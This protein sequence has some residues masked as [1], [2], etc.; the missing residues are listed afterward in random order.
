MADYE[1]YKFR[2]HGQERTGYF[3]SPFGERIAR[4]THLKSG[5]KVPVTGHKIPGLEQRYPT[6]EDALRDIA[7]K[8]REM[9]GEGLDDPI[10]QPTEARTVI[11]GTVNNL[12]INQNSLGIQITSAQVKDINAEID[13]APPGMLKKILKEWIP[14]ACTREGIKLLLVMLGLGSS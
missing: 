10:L 7:D 8:H 14:K 2:Y 12:Q 1:G 13:K 3:F 11:N 5:V 9:R 6:M 4:F